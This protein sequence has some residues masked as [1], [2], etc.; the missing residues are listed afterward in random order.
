[1]IR[2]RHVQALALAGLISALAVFAAEPRGQSAAIS[3]QA[4]AV[5][6]D[7]L[8]IGGESIRIYGIDAPE[9]DQVCTARDGGT[10]P[11]G[12]MASERL[13]RLVG[14]HL[15]V[16]ET[17]ERD[18]YDRAVARCEAAGGDVADTLVAEGLA[19]AYRQYSDAYVDAE[20]APRHAGIGVWQSETEPPW[21]YRRA[22]RSARVTQV[23]APAPPPDAECPIKGNIARS[24]EMIYHTP[25]SPHYSRT[26]IDQSKG[27]R[28]FC[29]E[30]AALDAGWRPPLTY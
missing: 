7:T 14:G 11:C 4:R 13:S 8:R 2:L 25:Q 28:W 9:T 1:M 12:A 10:W 16:C 29:N 21:R 3:G 27:E 26:R 5:D 15:V 23:S 30:T 20:A 18:I 24:G 19:W 22:Q 6:G 17:I